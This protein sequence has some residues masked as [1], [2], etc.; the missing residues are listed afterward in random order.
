MFNS[1]TLVFPF[2]NS[3]ISVES[4]CAAQMLVAAFEAT[5][6]TGGARGEMKCE[7]VA[8]GDAG[9]LILDSGGGAGATNPVREDTESVV[10]PV[11]SN[12]SKISIRFSNGK[13][14]MI[15]DINVC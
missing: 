10:V 12:N 5:V 15:Y 9:C 1:F 4:L 11:S 2:F 14:W 8:A 7:D 3:S 13:Y 6:T